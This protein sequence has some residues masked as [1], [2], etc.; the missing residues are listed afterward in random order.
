MLL[1][2][3]RSVLVSVV[4]YWSLSVFH[5]TTASV[6]VIAHPVKFAGAPRAKRNITKIKGR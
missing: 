4:R 5:R 1:R 3:R 2:E 6:M